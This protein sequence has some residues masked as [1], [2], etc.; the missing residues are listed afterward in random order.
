MQGN[1]HG[2]ADRHEDDTE[3]KEEDGAHAV[4]CCFLK[5]GNLDASYG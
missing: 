1:G 5:T 3:D 2:D 4:I